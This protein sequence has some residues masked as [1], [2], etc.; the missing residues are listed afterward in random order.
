MAL[1]FLIGVLAFRLALSMIGVG[2]LIGFLAPTL[3]NALGWA[4]AVAAA[5][6]GPVVA[7]FEEPGLE[8]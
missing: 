6:A 1:R 8:D 4:F 5:I 3:L 7:A 2:A